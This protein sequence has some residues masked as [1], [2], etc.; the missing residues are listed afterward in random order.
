MTTYPTTLNRY[1]PKAPTEK[2]GG[3]KKPS[4]ET[5]K[6]KK[7]DP[8]NLPKIQVLAKNNYGHINVGCLEYD[9]DGTVMCQLPGGLT[10]NIVTH[11]ILLDDLRILE[12]E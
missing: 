6:W 5:L 3:E 7:V 8:E 9:F 2:G 11:Y 12:S 4:F 10:M 1:I